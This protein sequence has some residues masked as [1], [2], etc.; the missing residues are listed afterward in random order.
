MKSRLSSNSGPSF[1]VRRSKWFSIQM[2]HETCFLFSYKKVN[3]N[4]PKLRMSQSHC[5]L[6]SLMKLPVILCYQELYFNNTSTRTEGER[7]SQEE[8]I[9]NNIISVEKYHS[10]I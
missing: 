2:K 1:R 10:C 3:V 7:S 4:V 9:T 5:L 8:L 6:F